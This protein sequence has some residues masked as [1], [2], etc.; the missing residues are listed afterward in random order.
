MGLKMSIMPLKPMLSLALGAA[1]AFWMTGCL[2]AQTASP[3]AVP[4]AVKT[5]VETAIEPA[6]ALANYVRESPFS[7]GAWHSSVIGSGGYL[8]HVVA[9]P[10]NPQRF[11]LTSDVGGLYRSDDGG[12]SWQMLHGHLPASGGNTE[13]R[14]LVVDPRDDRKV[15]IATGGPYG[16]PEGIYV[17]NDAGQSWKKRLTARFVG[18][19]GSRWTGR[20]LTRSA[21]NPDVLWC[22]SVGDGVF[23][24]SDNGASWTKSG[25]EGLNPNDLTL[26]RADEKRLWLSTGGG[27]V[28]GKQYKSGFYRSEDGGAHWGQIEGETPS[29]IVQDPINTALIYGIFGNALIKRSADGGATWQDWSDGLLTEAPENGKSKPSVSKTTYRAITTGPDFILTCNT[30]DADFFKLQSGGDKWE[31]IERHSVEAGDWYGARNDWYFG[32]AAGSITVDP[33]DA[34]HWFVTDYYACWQ[35]RD[36]GKNW[37]LTIDGVEMTVIHCLQQ[38]PSNANIVHVGAADVGAFTSRDGG[39]RFVH[40]AVPNAG[41]LRD[42]GGNMKCIDISPRAPDRLYAVGNRDG[43]AGWAANQV[44]VSTDNGQVWKRTPMTGLPDMNTQRCTTIV[45]DLND[46]NTV[47]LTVS[48]RIKPNWGGVYKSTD[49]AQTWTQISEGLPTDTYY[50]P[51]DIWAHGRQLAVDGNGVLLAIS[52]GDNRVYRFDPKTQQWSNTGFRAKGK[53]WSVTADRLKPGRFFIGAQNDGLYRTD[54]GGANWAKIYAQSVTNI[55]TDDAVQGRVAAG[56]SDGVILSVDGGQTWTM[57]DQALPYRA[58]NVPAFAG[59]R[60]IVGSGGSGVFWMDLP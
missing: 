22:A 56:T 8:Q 1:T 55:A 16:D 28:K 25:G 57:L 13:V 4:S 49:G 7:Y 14:G 29:E 48:G 51:S 3:S 21:Q 41:K 58:D 50:F 39:R 26:D 35:T 60:L 30:R 40:G 42:G 10:T 11:Y 32:G 23:K 53:L 37:R 18:N 43:N 44:F 9:C 45:A 38:D 46:A 20:V 19:G 36:A 17:S 2:H 54:D 24:S 27:K 12:Q 47:Y 34:A 15:A 6:V 33:G 52:Q 31:K 5:P 59:N